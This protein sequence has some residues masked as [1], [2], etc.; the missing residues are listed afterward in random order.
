MLEAIC[1]YKPPTGRMG[2]IE[3]IKGTLIIDDTYNSSPAAVMAALDATA[4]LKRF[5]A[6]RPH[7]VIAVLGDML[8]LGRHSVVEHRKMGAH[9]ASIANL[10]ITVGFRARDIAQGA[11]DEGMSDTAILQYEDSETAGKEL[12]NILKEGDCVL[13]KG[14]QSMRMEKIVEEIMAYPERAKNLL[15][16]QEEEWK[17]R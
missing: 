17:R 3:G 11:L 6:E 1:F 13:V 15:V 9:A 7:R 5:L 4:L 12:Q 2:I 8:E 16:R 10:L 14:S